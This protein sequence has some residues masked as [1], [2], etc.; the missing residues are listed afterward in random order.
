MR[1][2]SIQLAWF[3]GA[4]DL[5]SLEPDCKSMVVY[6]MNGSGKSSFVDAVEYVLRDGSIG[7]LSH[8]YSGTHQVKAVINTHKPPARK[9]GFRIKFQDNSEMVT[10]VKQNGSSASSGADAIAMGTWEYRQ[11]VLRQYEIRGAI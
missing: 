11:T 5:V 6:G 1:I 9:T 8:E 3:R 7:H 4:A 10:E 2:K